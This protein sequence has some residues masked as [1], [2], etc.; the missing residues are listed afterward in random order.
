VIKLEE[1]SWVRHVARI[2]KMRSVQE[3]LVLFHDDGHLGDRCIWE[4]NIKMDCK[5]K[6]KG[7]SLTVLV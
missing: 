3:A 4:G 1:L 2:G 5:Y 6:V 7:L